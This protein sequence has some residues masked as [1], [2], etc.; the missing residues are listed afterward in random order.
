[1][2]TKLADVTDLI[3]AVSASITPINPRYVG[4]TNHSMVNM[5]LIK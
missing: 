4:L 2:F 5:I 3:V 1:M